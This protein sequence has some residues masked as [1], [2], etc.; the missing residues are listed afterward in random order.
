[1]EFG[2]NVGFEFN[3]LHLGLILQNDTGN[4]FRNTTIIIPITDYKDGKFDK[5]VN[6]KLTNDD[7]E[8]KVLN[9]LVKDPSK[10]KLE[11]IRVIDKARLGVKIGKVKP[12]YMKVVE[13]KLK[14]LL[15]F[16]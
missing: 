16:D 1:V 7:L 5:H 10:L 3:S 13:N 4:T 11:D 15:S 14:K 12:D 2:I 8:S 9:G 6:I